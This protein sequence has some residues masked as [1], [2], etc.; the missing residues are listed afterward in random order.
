M[1]QFKIGLTGGI[2]S[3]KSTV[4]AMLEDYGIT[5]IDADKISRA[6]TGNGGAAIAAISAA[7][8]PDMI[9]DHGALDRRKMRDLV[10]KQSAARAQLEA[11][12]HPIV[13]EQMQRQADQAD[14]PYIVYDIP[15]LIESIGRYRSQ[16]KRICVVDCD[17]ATQISRV[18]SR[19]QLAIDEIKRIMDNQA[20]REQRLKHADDIISNGSGVDIAELQRQVHEKH[21]FWLELSAKD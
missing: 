20:S 16:F 5:I 14:S 13:Q 2:G 10:F 21:E 4:T 9:D 17:E 7:F 3:G 18:Q 1:K 15:L 19:S 12:V 11:I 6:S 8:G